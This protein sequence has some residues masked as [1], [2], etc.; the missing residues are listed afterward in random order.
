MSAIYK[1]LLSATSNTRDLGGY[2]TV[3]GR[4]T[5]RN[6]IWR[7]DA[8]T[9]WNASDLRTLAEHGMTSIIDRRTRQEAEKHP[10]AYA[11]EKGIAYHAFPIAAGSVP[12]STLAGVPQS[13]M[14]IVCQKE[15]SDVLRTVAESEEG[16]FICCTAGKD[17]TG[18]IS[19]VLLLSCGVEREAIIRDYVVSR[20]YNRQRLERYLAEHPEVDRKIVLANE[21]SMAQFMDMFFD[22]YGNVENYYLKAGLT[23]GHLAK[24]SRKLLESGPSTQQEFGKRACDKAKI[25][26]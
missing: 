23:L 11:S 6:I 10:C 20:E 16:V 5:R 12:P 1:S 4:V 9:A 7:S 15:T 24:I 18:V 17:R 8:P 13:Y 14:E 3:S 2:P 25:T 19:A 22:Q 26:G 21:T